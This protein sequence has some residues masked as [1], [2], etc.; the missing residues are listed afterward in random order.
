VAAT[1]RGGPNAVSVIIGGKG[2]ASAPAGGLSLNVHSLSATVVAR[3]VMSA[4]GAS[5]FVVTGAGF[6]TTTCSKN[7]VSVGS[8]ACLVTACTPTTLVATYPGDLAANATDSI[9]TTVTA[10]A[11]ALSIA[12]EDVSGTEVQSGSYSA[13]VAVTAGG[14]SA[15]FCALADSSANATFGAS[16]TLELQCSSA[17][18]QQKVLALHIVSTTKAG[19]AASGDGARRRLSAA[20]SSV[21]HPRRRLHQEEPSSFPDVPESE[22]GTNEPDP[23]VCK[24]T[25][26]AA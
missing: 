16:A 17:A 7:K 26:L 8:V 12:V 6:D 10:E 14:A 22:L 23:I 25:T 18:V 3:S 5:R 19:M 13:L 4:I 2:L 11:Q 20:S 1:T 9:D 15:P 24:V 21:V